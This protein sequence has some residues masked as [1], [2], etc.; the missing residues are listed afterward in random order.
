MAMSVAMTGNEIET[1]LNSFGVLTS[2]P[3]TQEIGDAAMQE[4]ETS[5]RV[6]AIDK[7]KPTTNIETT[8]EV[9]AAKEGTPSNQGDVSTGSTTDTAPTGPAELQSNR[10]AST[11]TH[12]FKVTAP[13]IN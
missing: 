13:Q 7:I 1:H 3:D 2:L 10:E 4:I 12:A 5:A 6:D 11:L 9:K 8:S